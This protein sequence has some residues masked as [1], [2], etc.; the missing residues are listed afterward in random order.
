MQSLRDELARSSFVDQERNI[1]FD[2]ADFLRENTHQLQEL[3]ATF[4]ILPSGTFGQKEYD[5]L[6]RKLA[7]KVKQ[8]ESF[9]SKLHSEKQAFLEKAKD[10]RS[11][12]SYEDFH[13]QSKKA[14]EAFKSQVL[15]YLESYLKEDFPDLFQEARE[16]IESIHFTAEKA[17]FEIGFRKKEQEKRAAVERS[18]DE[19][20]SKINAV[21]MQ[22]GDRVSVEIDDQES[23]IHSG[24][25][26]S[27]SR[28]FAR[29]KQEIQE[30]INKIERFI[31]GV[32]DS[33]RR[34]GYQDRLTELLQGNHAGDAY[35]YIELF[36]E[37]RAAEQTLQWKSRI[38]DAIVAINQTDVN[39]QFLP[40]RSEII[41]FGFSLIEKEKIKP[42]EHEDFKAKLELFKQENER[43]LRQEFIME[44]ERQF[45]KVQLVQI[46]EGLNYDVVDD[47]EVIDFE[48][49]SDFLLRI[50]NQSNYLNLRFN[51][52]GSFLYNFL[53]PENKND[54]S[55][56]QKQQRLSEMESTCRE[57]KKVLAELA[58]LGINVNL[59]SEMPVSG[60]ALI[61]VPKRHRT[62]TQISSSPKRARK[63][64]RKQKQ[65]KK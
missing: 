30:Q 62:R 39:Q 17:Q 25:E 52:D 23:F 47:M 51:E 4:S 40:N 48:K 22:I 1:Q 57:F 14:F 65:L 10:Y 35:F 5:R 11:F 33:H 29:N 38:Q 58:G 55:I 6:S 37:I 53:I 8:L 46:M 56:S 7:K 13:K 3:V 42:Y 9:I 49:E 64:S 32:E 45:L 16:S 61:Q 28:G 50:P 21:R 19:R 18:I 63:K 26:D 43:A 20:R 24:T 44:K 2:C 27:E 15:H 31:S 34:G 41:Q 60:K 12:V 36:E 54:L 59:E